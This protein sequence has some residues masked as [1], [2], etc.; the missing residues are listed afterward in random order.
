MN[1]PIAERA[2]KEMT[3]EFLMNLKKAKKGKT[4]LAE[5][6]KIHMERVIA[7]YLYHLRIEAPGE[8]AIETDARVKLDM[9][10]GVAIKIVS[11]NL[12]YVGYIEEINVLGKNKHLIN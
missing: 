6:I 12:E 1:K 10:M 9:K 8:F 3:D 5:M 4:D 2:A 7:S 11:G